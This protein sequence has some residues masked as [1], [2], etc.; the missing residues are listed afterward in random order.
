MNV[1]CKQRIPVSNDA[2]TDRN[3]VVQICRV[4]TY[5]RSLL[6]HGPEGAL[7][8]AFWWPFDNTLSCLRLRPRPRLRLAAAQA[9][10]WGHNLCWDCGQQGHLEGLQHCVDLPAVE[11]GRRNFLQRVR[12]AQLSPPLATSA[13]SAGRSSPETAHEKCAVGPA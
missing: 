7:V 8:P 4:G 12:A 6:P 1:N 13:V 9:K 11:R 3:D 2:K 5:S 10:G